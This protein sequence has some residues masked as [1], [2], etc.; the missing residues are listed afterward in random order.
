[1]R[2][3]VAGPYSGPNVIDI[4]AKMRKGLMVTIDVLKKG[5]APF[6]PWLD[7]QF[8]LVADD[9]TI[10]MYYRFSMEWLEGA[11]AVLMVP[12]WEISK[13]ASKERDRAIELGIPVYYSVDELPAG[14]PMGV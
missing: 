6:S 3:Y 14:K 2:V 7:F 1:M 10:D 12:G 13:G 8:G 4:L 11:E 5:H 9:I